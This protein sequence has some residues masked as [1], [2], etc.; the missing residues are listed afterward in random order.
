MKKFSVLPFLLMFSLIIFYTGC[1]DKSTEP[2]TTTLTQSADDNAAV[3]GEYNSI[4]SMADAQGSISYSSAEQNKNSNIPLGITDKS[5]L[6]PLCANITFDTTT[7]TLTIDF[8]TSDCQCW[9][10][11]YR[12]GKIIAVFTGK[13]R[14]IGSSVNI[15]LDNYYINDMLL[16]G[17]KEITITAAH[18]WHVVV[19]GAILHTPTGNITWDCDR[20]TTKTAGYD[21]PIIWRDDVYSI[22]GTANGVNRKGVA[23]SATVDQNNPLIKEMSCA[24]KDFVSG[25]LTIINSKGDTLSVNYDPTGTE[26]CDKLVNVTINGKTY[27]IYLR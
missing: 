10:G 15:S 7:H 5:D 17:T 2:A 27:T 20:I 14:T 22:T 18:Q 16:E 23:F 24:K 6:L 13:W 4:F 3:D 9:D 1:K 25:I 21:T 8:G 26:L 11:N 12:K 19:T